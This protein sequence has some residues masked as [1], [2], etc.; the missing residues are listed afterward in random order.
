MQ[1]G[2]GAEGKVM[3][4]LKKSRR[5]SRQ[6]GVGGGAVGG[7]CDGRSAHPIGPRTERRTRCPFVTLSPAYQTLRL[8]PQLSRY[9][10]C[11]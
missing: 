6:G 4:I 10:T 8:P 9:E 1:T 11:A 2:D 7:G 5:R 3:C